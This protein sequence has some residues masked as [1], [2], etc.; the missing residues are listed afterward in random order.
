MPNTKSAERRA[1]ANET[2]RLRNRAA[3][4]R[5]KSMEKT[6]LSLLQGG[7]KDEAATAYRN[8]SSTLDKAS[9]AGVIPKPTASRKRSHSALA[10]GKLK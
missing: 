2:K 6:F 7:K 5:L 9:K 4:S 1:R 3:K 10:L 8:L